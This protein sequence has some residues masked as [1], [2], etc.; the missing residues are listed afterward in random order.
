MSKAVTGGAEREFTAPL[1]S[2]AVLHL[3]KTA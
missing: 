2:D 1:S 3:R